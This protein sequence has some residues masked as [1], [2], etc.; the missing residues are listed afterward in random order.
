MA[1]KTKKNPPYNLL[2]KI[3]VNENIARY[4]RY[5]TLEDRK[6]AIQLYEENIKFNIYCKSYLELTIVY[7]E[8]M[9][10]DKAIN[11]AKKGINVHLEYKKPTDFFEIQILTDTKTDPKTERKINYNNIRGEQL[12]EEGNIDDAIKYYEKNVNLIAYTPKTYL[13]LSSLY[14]QKRDY[15]SAKEI[16][17]LAI[18]RFSTKTDIY[19][20][21]ETI[22]KRDL[23][24]I[25]SF[26]ETGTWKY[27]GLPRDPN[28]L[29]HDI[30][31]AEKILMGARK[32]KKRGQKTKKSAYKYLEE[33]FE[34]GTYTNKVYRILYESYYSD[35]RYD[36][37]IRVCEK[38]IE[39]LG[40]YPNGKKD[41]WEI[42]LRKAI[43][44]KEKVKPEILPQV[45]KVHQERENK[46]NDLL[47][48]GRVEEAIKL[49]EVNVNEM[50]LSDNTYNK[51]VKIYMDLG[52]NDDAKRVCLQAIEVMKPFSHKKVKQYRNKMFEIIMGYPP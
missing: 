39:V 8:E 44:R 5:G 42:N 49:Y 37:A 34:N 23:E 29:L 18:K 48:Q 52:K 16:L 4:L 51:L 14:L 33:I 9:E 21:Y 32:R 40:V 3:R 15:E 45:E 19:E 35:K 28:Y 47:K 26:M 38:A 20:N 24:D 1:S 43:K 36:D 11:V 13:N 10:Y 41:R 2:E 30:N 17:K 6:K 12:K 46:A 27:R 25:E 22:F 31:F 7:M 50:A